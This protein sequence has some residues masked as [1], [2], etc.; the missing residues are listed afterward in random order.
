M[1]LEVV[2]V[3]VPTPNHNVEELPES[4]GS[5]LRSISRAYASLACKL[6]EHCIAYVPEVRQRHTTPQAEFEACN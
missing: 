2:L 6:E 5:N 1:C 4:R 3:A